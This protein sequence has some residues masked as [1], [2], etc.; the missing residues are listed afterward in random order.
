MS[1][2]SR[3]MFRGLATPTTNCGHWS[4]A[5]ARPPGTRPRPPFRILRRRTRRRTRRATSMRTMA[6]AAGSC[7][8]L[9]AE[10]AAAARVAVWLGLDR[11][12]FR[13]W[14]GWRALWPR[15]WVRRSCAPCFA[16]ALLSRSTTVR[17]RGN[18]LPTSAPSPGVSQPFRAPSARSSRSGFGP[19]PVSMPRC[20]SAA[21]AAAVEASCVLGTGLHRR[22]PLAAPP[23]RD[24]GRQALGASPARSW[25]PGHHALLPRLHSRSRPRHLLQRP[26]VR[27]V[28]RWSRRRYG[29][30]RP[31]RWPTSVPPR[32]LLGAPKRP[33]GFQIWRASGRRQRCGWLGR[34]SSARARRIRRF[35]PLAALCRPR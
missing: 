5:C 34:R 32:M 17:V 31:P 1:R 25:S 3:C 16:L 23:G 6:I 27:P 20:G 2:A 13:G 15:T 8:A 28:Q 21:S 11:R 4:L 35:G 14:P 7:A 19:S 22:P 33:G 18:W 30:P 10:A 9:G 24:H 26:L 29:M 12:C